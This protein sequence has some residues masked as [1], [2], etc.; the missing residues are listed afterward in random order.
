M[1]KILKEKK[2]YFATNNRYISNING[3]T[4]RNM[5]PNVCQYI[6]FFCHT[7]GILVDPQNKKKTFY[8]LIKMFVNVLH[9]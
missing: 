9:H 4:K 3:W 8:S 5:G 7:T 1:K 2:S 6:F